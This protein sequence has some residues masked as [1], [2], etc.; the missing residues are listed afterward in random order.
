MKKLEILLLS[1]VVLIAFG[2]RIYK[3]NRPIADWH[4]W[5]QADTAAVARNFTKEGFNP[6]IPTYDDMSSQTNT[7]DNP[8]RYRFVEFP[9]YNSIIAAV[10]AVTGINVTYARIVTV[11]I[12]LVSTVTLY[13]LVRKFSGITVAML[14]AFFFATIP[15]NV[16][17]SSTILPAPL[18]VFAVLLMYLSFTN[19]LEK[20]KSL[21]WAGLTIIAANVAILVWPIALFFTLPIIY[22]ALQKYGF[23]AIKKLNLWVFAIAALAPFFA[24]RFWMTKF[25]SGIP[26][27]Q[28]LINEGNIRFKGAF[29]RW[30]I[31]ERLGNIILTVGGFALFILGLVR[32]PEAKEKYFYY[33][34]LA[35]VALYFI[36]FASGNVR[37]DYYQVPIVPIFA[38]FMALG[39]K[40]LIDKPN[41][42]FNKY[43]GIL[44][45]L[46][47]ILFMYAFG[48]YQIQG[49][50]WI[51][52]P[53]IVEAGQAAD[54]ILPKNA[55]VI[56]PYNGDT[57]FLYQ[58]NRHGYPIVDRP[59]EDFVKN[60]TQYLISVDVNDAGIQN[61]AKNCRVL[62]E[63]PDYLI[64]QLSLDCIGK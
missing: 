61:L 32:K 18:M 35:S 51:N 21:L 59:L 12:S 28:F 29:F 42:Y 9:I 6:L 55:T 39:V 64:I 41:E 48:F 38:V 8:N 20:E 7:L 17:Y 62:K 26:N 24:W 60:G 4:S 34:W 10:W 63:T 57:A 47:L 13:F 50:Y 49:Y 53:Q 36:V 5:R 44:T 58:T 14:S 46:A 37:H 54:R 56:A 19:W 1:L 25:P 31:S 27:W 40:F 23:S 33:S 45:A 15:Y 16:F 30:L 3:I 11:I 43:V 2:A 22:L 52:R